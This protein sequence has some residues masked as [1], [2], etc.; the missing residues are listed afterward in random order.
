MNDLI[1]VG[2]GPAALAAAIYAHAKQLDWLLIYEELGGQAIWRQSVVGPS[3][4]EHRPGEESVRVF[5]RQIAHSG[6]AHHDHVMSITKSGNTFHVTT[7]RHGR[8]EAVAILLATGTTPIQ[9]DAPGVQKFLGKGLGYAITSDAHLLAGKDVAVI[10]QTNHALRGTTE[11]AQTA[12]Q[13][14]LIVTD[15]SVQYSPRA[16]ELQRYSNVEILQDA[17]VHEIAGTTSAEEVVVEYAGRMRRLAVDAA[18][19]DLG[20]RPNVAMVRDLLGLDATTFVAVDTKH[21]SAV[22][23]LYAAGNVTTTLSEQTLRAIGDGAHAAVGTY[24]YIL[25]ARARHG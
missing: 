13:V 15:R 3:D 11:V 9:L 23:G 20:I 10:G 7:R 5:E 17:R 2:G 21:A 22:P 1:I 6:R 12:R 19:V 24:E 14:Y 8:H 16:E 4:D 25:A 18:F